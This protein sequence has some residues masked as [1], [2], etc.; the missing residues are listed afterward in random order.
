MCYVSK[1]FFLITLCQLAYCRV[2]LQAF[3]NTAKEIYQKI[4]DGVF[5]I[6]NEVRTNLNWI[7]FPS[8]DILVPDFDG[9]GYL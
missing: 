1:T 7:F 9:V 6:N 8:L 4:Q 3:I 5:D 2:C